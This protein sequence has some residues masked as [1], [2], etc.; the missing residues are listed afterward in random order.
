VGLY[1]TMLA[2]DPMFSTP[3]PRSK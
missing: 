2:E 3:Y 1:R